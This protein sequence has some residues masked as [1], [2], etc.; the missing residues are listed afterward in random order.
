MCLRVRE[1]PHVVNDAGA[2][3]AAPLGFNVSRLALPAQ[4]PVH[5]RPPDPEHHCGRFVRAG[6]PAP[7]RR[8][9]SPPQIQRDGAH[10]KV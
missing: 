1:Q 10:L 8:N 9:H 2:I 5:R 6:Q 3:A 4:Q 7:V